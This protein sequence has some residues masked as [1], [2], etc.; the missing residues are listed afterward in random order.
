MSAWTDR[1]TKFYY[2]QLK[3]DKNYKFKDAL[4]ELS[5]LEKA[6]KDENK[7]SGK[8]TP[9]QKKTPAKKD[10]DKDKKKK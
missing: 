1:V 6:N 2:E 8:K 10:A 5:E 9:V 7:A 4:K 3:K